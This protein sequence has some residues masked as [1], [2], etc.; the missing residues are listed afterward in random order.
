MTDS[1]KIMSRAIATYGAQA[2]IDKAIE[3][4]S[5]LIKALL[6]DR[7]KTK[8]YEVQIMRDAVAEEIADVMIMLKQ[9]RMIYDCDG[10]I[11]DYQ[12]D[13]LIRLEKRLN[14]AAKA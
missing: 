5:E 11:L 8:D 9:L 12:D 4:M 7:H 14:E 10:K 13:K 6:K 1:E 2:Q 3:E